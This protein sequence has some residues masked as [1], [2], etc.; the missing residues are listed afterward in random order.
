MD[1][2]DQL[3][4]DG[5]KIELEVRGIENENEELNLAA[6]VKALESER[7]KV[8]NPPM[9]AHVNATKIQRQN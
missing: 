5:V 3:D 2:I 6:L 4:A 7:T 1:Y 8:K 9:K